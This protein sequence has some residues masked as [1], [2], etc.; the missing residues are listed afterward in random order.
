[1]G[2]LHAGLAQG[3]RQNSP[4]PRR[5]PSPPQ[6]ATPA[7]LGALA[8]LGLAVHKGYASQYLTAAIA[9]SAGQSLLAQKARGG[10]GWGARLRH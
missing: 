7:L 4:T 9:A 8:V 6:L 5:P 1:M 2:W 3:R 10:G